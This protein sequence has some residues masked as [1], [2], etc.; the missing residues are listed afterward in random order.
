VVFTTAMLLMRGPELL[1]V[2]GNSVLDH[3]SLNTPRPPPAPRGTSKSYRGARNKERSDKVT[4][5]GVKT[6]ES[7]SG[8]TNHDW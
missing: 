4:A 3:C 6:G 1:V 5:G 8:I 2:L 7:L